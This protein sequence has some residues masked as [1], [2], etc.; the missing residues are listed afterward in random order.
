MKI[1]VQTVH[2]DAD[3]RL[4]AFV[5]D[6]VQRLSR[7]FGQILEVE[8]Y[9]RL[10]HTGGKVQDKIAEIKLHLPG[11]IIIDKKISSSFENAILVSVDSLKRQVQKKKGKLMDKHQS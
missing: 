10:Q 8:V 4:L 7:Y 1:Q 3:T 6:R 5:E 9:L 11:S 2:F